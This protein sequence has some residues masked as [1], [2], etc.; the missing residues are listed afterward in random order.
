MWT[1]TTSQHP[2]RATCHKQFK[3]WTEEVMVDD[4]AVL[5]C[6][7]YPSLV[8]LYA[9]HIGEE[10]LWQVEVLPWK[11]I[12]A[13]VTGEWNRLGGEFQKKAT[14]I[15]NE[16]AGNGMFEYLVWPGPTSSYFITTSC[17]RNLRNLGATKKPNA[18]QHL[19]ICWRS[20][21]SSPEIPIYSGRKD[22]KR[23]KN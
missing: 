4:L 22:R 19:K 18:L 5:L 8:S 7:T 23:Q 21:D 9:H 20:T 11:S 17:Q 14:E 2:R 16:T 1:R 6:S 3:Q 15:W 12:P 13:Q 10:L